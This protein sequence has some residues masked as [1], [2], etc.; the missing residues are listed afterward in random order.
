MKK[1]VLAT[2]ISGLCITPAWAADEPAKADPF[3]E[4]LQKVQQS[5]IEET[6]ENRQR[7]K[8]F[9]DEESKRAAMLA[10][11]KQELAAEKVRSTRL[12]A[13]FDKNEK[14]L[15]VLETELREQLGS[16]GEVFGVVRQVA[17]DARANFQNSIT[18]AHIKDR[19]PFLGELA[20]SKELPDIA[21]LEKLWFELQR[22]IIESGKVV[23]FESPILLPDG[24][25][26]N[27]PTVRVGLF[28]L[29]SDGEFLRYLSDTDKVAEL[30]RQPAGQYGS[31][32]GDL[33]DA[34]EGFVEMAV[35]PSRGVILS[36]LVQTPNLFERLA[37][38]KLVGYI[39]VLLGLA[40]LAI[41]AHRYLALNK[42]DA[43]VKRQLQSKTADPTNPLGRILS[44]YEQNR[45]TD[46]E[47][48]ELKID[49]A[50]LKDIPE[51]EKGL[52]IIKIL[53]VIAPLLG[54]LGTVTGMIETFQAI[55][56]FGTGD[57]KLM[58]GGISQALVTT[59]LGLVTAIPLVLLYTVV[60][61]KS[62]FIIGVL[63][64]QSAGLIAMHAE[65]A[66]S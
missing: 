38:G 14:K 59:V 11:A 56:L 64:E 9:A 55:T 2:L 25:E 31:M 35:D 6:A 40:G 1:L 53:A 17:G 20:K 51:I 52:P 29:V 44:V 12:K 50:I 16:L 28:N 65:G 18:S 26:E 62:K 54:L 57:P 7:L 47:T 15:T 21:K 13:D 46:V 39:I 41:V 45:N 34:K 66:K 4:L 23:K 42:I 48:L 37:Q 3:A 36:L 10:K 43:A 5:K 22:E 49:E 61:T 58:A 19:Q 60:H 8:K 24:G 27:R 63:E 33:E 32:A 30:S